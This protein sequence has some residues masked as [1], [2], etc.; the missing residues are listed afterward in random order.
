MKKPIAEVGPWKIMDQAEN[1]NEFIVV[2][3]RPDWIL[4]FR[5]NGAFISPNKTV[6]ILTKLCKTLKL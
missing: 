6:E 3:D 2:N 5:T 4:I 1:P